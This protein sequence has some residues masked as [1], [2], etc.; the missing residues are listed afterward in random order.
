MENEVAKIVIKS[1]A[2]LL[3]LRIFVSFAPFLSAHI[4]ENR[5]K[6]REKERLP[7]YANLVFRIM[8]IYYIFI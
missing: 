2:F 5:I 1:H 3:D 7:T 8:D 6:G 4:H